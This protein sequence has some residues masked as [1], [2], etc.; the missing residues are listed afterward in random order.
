M[1]TELV[2][3][4]GYKIAADAISKGSKL[5]SRIAPSLSGQ[6]SF[7]T[8]ELGKKYSLPYRPIVLPKLNS[9]EIGNLERL[10]DDNCIRKSQSIICAV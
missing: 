3:K 7:D 5:K 4:T 1:L 2:M 8:L 9:L 10:D 6:L